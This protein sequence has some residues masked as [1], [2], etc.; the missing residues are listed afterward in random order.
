M[1][2]EQVLWNICRWE[3]QGAASAEIYQDPAVIADSEDVRLE[4]TGYIRGDTEQH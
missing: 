3:W 4:R 2:K 1:Q